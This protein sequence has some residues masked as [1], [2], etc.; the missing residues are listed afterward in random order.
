V[1]L[2]QAGPAYPANWALVFACGFAGLTLSL[3]AILC[4]REEPG[5]VAHATV[6]VRRSIGAMARYLREDARLRRAALSQITLGLAASTFPFFIIRAGQLLPRDGE[7]TGTFLVIQ[8]AGGILAALI[9]GYLID[10]VG[11]RAAIR[12]G[13][14]MQCIALL[15]VT[16]ARVTGAP[17]ALYSL[18][19]LLL[20]FVVGS[21]WWSYGA[22]LLEIASDEQRPTYLAAYGILTGSPVF[23]GSIAVGSVFALLVPE[24]IFAVALG[25]SL[26]GLRIAWSMGHGRPP[27]EPAN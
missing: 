25:I 4:V 7:M 14:G 19:F 3:V 16:V 23:V 20:G 11:S 12:A 21:S 18:A 26:V 5:E 24:A 1:I 10:R 15:A 27:V 9:C 22:Y 2:G 8:S 17:Q 6:S 13:A